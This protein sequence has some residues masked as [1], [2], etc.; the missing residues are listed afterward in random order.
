[1]LALDWGGRRKAG[2]K[3]GDTIS[4]GLEILPPPRRG[5]D[6]PIFFSNFKIYNHFRRKRHFCTQATAFATVNPGCKLL[7]GLSFLRPCLHTGIP[8]ATFSLSNFLFLQSRLQPI[9][10]VV[11]QLQ[12]GRKFTTGSAVAKFVV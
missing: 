6:A 11:Y 12:C 8:V 10:T 1:M 5:F 4:A 2:V 3:L 9:L 7:S